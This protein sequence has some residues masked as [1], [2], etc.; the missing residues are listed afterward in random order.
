MMKRYGCLAHLDDRYTWAEA[1]D[2][3]S[4]L[5]GVPSESTSAFEPLQDPHVCDR[6]RSKA[7]EWTA[8][9]WQLAREW[10]HE[11]VAVFV[12]NLP[13][14][15]GRWQA[16]SGRLGDLNISAER[17]PGFDMSTERDRDAAYK[18]GAILEG[19]NISLAQGHA[20][21]S[22][23]AA[24]SGIMGN[25]GVAAGHFRALARAAD[26][27]K[28][29]ALVLEDDAHPDEDFVPQV[30]SLAQ[31]ELPCG[32]D[33]VS[34]SSRC[35]FGQCI[36]RRLSRVS[37]DAN[38]PEWR[39]RHGVNYG[40]FS[41]LYRTAALAGLRERWQL[42]VFDAARP[43]CLDV[44]VALAS[45][46]DAVNFYAVPSLQA[47]VEERDYYLGGSERIRINGAAGPSSE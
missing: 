4:G 42:A 25:L 13:S 7:R 28:P 27:G 17:V 16:V 19:Y 23:G 20:A 22:H 43:Y 34:L 47:F 37:P 1:Q 44:D 45:I 30:W 14:A 3:A 8:E 32:W 15:R 46:S 9:E 2:A 40:F 10:F 36:S 11:N 29:V 41:V 31:E 12:L 39:C 24:K 21:L 38:E 18:E 35:P 6:R 26:A 33:A 5:G